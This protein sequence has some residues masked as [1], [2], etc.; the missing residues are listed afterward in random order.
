MMK[1]RKNAY[2]M[3]CIMVLVVLKVTISVV[4]KF[5]KDDNAEE[6]MNADPKEGHCPE[7]VVR[8]KKNFMDYVIDESSSGKL[9]HGSAAIFLKAVKGWSI[10]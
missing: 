9:R 7:N 4:W 2:C 10:F 1:I 6:V 5:K 8:K 3:L